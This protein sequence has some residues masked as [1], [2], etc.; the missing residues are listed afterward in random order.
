M[1]TEIRRVLEQNGI[2]VELDGA[3]L[4]SAVAGFMKSV[5]GN[6]FSIQDFIKGVQS[7]G[8]FWK[9]EDDCVV[10]LGPD[11]DSIAKEIDEMSDDKDRN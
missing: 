7:C 5:E 11:V 8:T 10:F 2:S 3:V 9:V 6:G 4:A 1:L